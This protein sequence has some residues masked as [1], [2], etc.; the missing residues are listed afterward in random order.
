MDKKY[1]VIRYKR[2]GPIGGTN[3]T[4]AEATAYQNDLSVSGTEDL[5]LWEPVEEEKEDEP[6]TGD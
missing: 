3:M 4:W 1:T 5:Y 2:M 6:S